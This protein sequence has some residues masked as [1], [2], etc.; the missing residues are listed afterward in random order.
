MKSKINTNLFDLKLSQAENIEELHQLLEN[1]LIQPVTW[2]SM[3]HQILKSKNINEKTAKQLFVQHS[4][5]KSIAPKWV[6]QVPAKRISILQ[7]S[8]ALN[9]DV[10][11]TNELLF[12]NGFHKLY[13][14]DR[15]DC[16]WIY[17]LTNKSK[18]CLEEENPKYYAYNVFNTLS[19]ECSKLTSSSHAPLSIDTDLFSKELMSIENLQSFYQFFESHLKEFKSCGS[20]AYHYINKWCNQ[21]ILKELKEGYPKNPKY[22]LSSIS[23]YISD[24]KTGHDLPER[25][26][27]IFI[28]LTLRFPLNNINHLLELCGMKPLYSKE[29]QEALIIYKLEELYILFPHWFDL[30]TEQAIHLVLKED[31]YFN[32]LCFDSNFDD[33][34]DRTLADYIH[35]FIDEYNHIY[36]NER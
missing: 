34:Q 17:M 18:L 22:K 6:N 15:N 10:E 33:F 29:K 31:Q 21:N 2:E 25:E 13:S 28:G 12:H 24:L 23:S 16:I 4:N 36:T 27:M 5:I 20:K 7:V 3:I 26:K 1:E 19:S 11:S 32:D 8:Y 9:L 30:N 35:D 14:K